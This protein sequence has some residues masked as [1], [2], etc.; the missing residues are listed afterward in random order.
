MACRAGKFRELCIDVKKRIA[1]SIQFLELFAATLR[2]NEMAR[3][4]V[5]R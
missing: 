4:A 5:I 3:I 2:K 1:V